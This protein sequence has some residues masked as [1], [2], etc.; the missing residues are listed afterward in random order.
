MTGSPALPR[1][2]W[3]MATAAG[4]DATFALHRARG[5]GLDIRWALNVFEGESGL[6]RFHGTPRPLVHAHARALGLEPVFGETDPGRGPDDP[7]RVDFEEAL[8]E[9][10]YRLR[11]AGACGVLFGN[12]HL[13]EIRDWYAS[14]VHGAGLVAHEP[15]WGIPPAEI[16]R[17][18]GEAGFRALVISVNLELGDPSWLGRHLDP[19]LVSA[20]EAAGIDPAGEHGEYHTFVHDG[21]GFHSPVPFRVRGHAERE[22]HR[23]LL[24]DPDELAPSP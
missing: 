5:E 14:R 18:V 23:F 17:G 24:L 4:K 22:G 1:G 7:D 9:C 15:L 13:E 11:E 3:A 6:V 21:P 20:F 8:R 10:L 16:A 12:L 2:P 19:E